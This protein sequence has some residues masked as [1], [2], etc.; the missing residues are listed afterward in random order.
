MFVE[1]VQQIADLPVKNVMNDLLE[2]YLYYEITE[3]AT[4]LMEVRKNIN[5]SPTLLSS[6]NKVY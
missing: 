4:T 5:F 6:L 3:A 2:L 1:Q